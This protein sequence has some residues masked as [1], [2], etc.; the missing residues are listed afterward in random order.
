M[1]VNVSKKDVFKPLEWKEKLEQIK[2]RHVSCIATPI[3]LRLVLLTAGLL[4]LADTILLPLLPVLKAVVGI[5]CSWDVLR[6]W[7]III[8][9]VET[10]RSHSVDIFRS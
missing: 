8:I 6:C 7:F 1:L 10:F 3:Q 5:A 2:K 9:N 4:P